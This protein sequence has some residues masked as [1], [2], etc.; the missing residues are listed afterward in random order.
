MNQKMII[1]HKLGENWNNNSI[2]DFFL[3]LGLFVD[4]EKECALG[5]SEVIHF[6]INV[7][8]SKELVLEFDDIQTD[9]LKGISNCE[10]KLPYIPQSNLIMLPHIGNY[11][12]RE[13]LISDGE[14][15]DF[16]ELY[17]IEAID[18]TAMTIR[19]RNEEDDED[20]IE[21]Q[22]IVVQQSNNKVGII[23]TNDLLSSRFPN[24]YTEIEY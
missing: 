10:A 13:A 11:M 14:P 1:R 7:A 21:G 9:I 16:F 8:N 4:F 18:G 22:I 15:Y 24:L 20:V 6:K 19:L 5:K 23:F 2:E 12:A 17:V 3:P